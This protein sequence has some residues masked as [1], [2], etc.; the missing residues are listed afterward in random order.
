MCKTLFNKNQNYKATEIAQAVYDITPGRYANVDSAIA[1]V[2]I[3]IRK[4]GITP[5]N[6]QRQNKVYSGLDCQKVLEHFAPARKQL[7]IKITEPTKN[8]TMKA[9]EAAKYSISADSI[10]AGK[11]DFSSYSKADLLRLKNDLDE[12]LKN[13]APDWDTMKPGDHFIF[14]LAAI[15]ASYEQRRQNAP[16]PNA[17]CQSR[18]LFVVLHPVRMLRKRM[19]LIDRDVPR[20]KLFLRRKKRIE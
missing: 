13:A 19:D 15:P 8:I 14:G 16:F 2:N 9:S 20:R 10:K 4:N 6:G 5:V 11:F 18:H 17:F 1:A 3:F 7:E 12:A